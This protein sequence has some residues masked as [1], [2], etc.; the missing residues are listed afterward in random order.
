MA[1]LRKSGSSEG[2]RWLLTSLADSTDT[3]SWLGEN[4]IRVRDVAAELT[5]KYMA[6]PSAGLT[7]SFESTPDQKAKDRRK[8]AQWLKAQIRQREAAQ[9]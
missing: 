8:Q 5:A 7:Y 3:G 4:P 6:P 1:R 2:Y 9:R